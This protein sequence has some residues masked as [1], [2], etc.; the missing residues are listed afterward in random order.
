MRREVE[1]KVAVT[2]EHHPVRAARAALLEAV[3]NY[4]ETFG[5]DPHWIDTTIMVKVNIFEA[6]AVL[7]EELEH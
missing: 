2:E 6:H 5:H 3:E 4:A 1:A 7:T